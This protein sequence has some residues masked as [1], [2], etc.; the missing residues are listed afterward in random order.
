[1][2]WYNTKYARNGHLFQDRFKSEP[3]ETETYF[4]TVLKY[5]HQNPIKTGICKRAEDYEYSSYRDY[6]QKSGVSFNIVKK[7]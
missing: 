4:I 7:L 2:Y 5:I 1:M 6:T 3:V